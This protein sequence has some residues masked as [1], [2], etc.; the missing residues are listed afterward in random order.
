MSVW[1]D[2]KGEWDSKE[3]S[4][5]ERNAVLHMMGKKNFR[6]FSRFFFLGIVLCTLPYK[7]EKK[8][9]LSLPPPPKK[10]PKTAVFLF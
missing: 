2:L 7:A 3:L 6:F 10:N 1:N 8:P 5:R 4:L 9:L